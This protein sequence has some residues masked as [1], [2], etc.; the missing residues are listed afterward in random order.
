MDIEQEYELVDISG[1]EDVLREHP[2][3][4]NKGDT[5][6]IGESIGVNGWYGA[7]TAQRSTGYILAGNHRFRA[8]LAHGAKEVPVIWKDVDDETALKILLVDNESTRRGENDEAKLEA[9]LASLT[10]LDG[11]GYVLRSAQ[12]TLD[13]DDEEAPAASA[14]GDGDPPDAED[15]PEDKYEPQWSVVILCKSERQQ[16]ETYRWLKEQMPKREMRLTAV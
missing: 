8:A 7:I 16:E 12:E 10:T 1:D 14:N 2:K 9:A 5:E 4:P 3:N 6:V 13:E 11:S 15:V